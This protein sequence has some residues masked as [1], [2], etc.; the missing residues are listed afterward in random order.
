[1]FEVIGKIVT[2]TGPRLIADKGGSDAEG[3]IGLM[4]LLRR[5]R[6]L[7]LHCGCYLIY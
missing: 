6:T 1:M 7:L 5:T 2:G 4:W 3:R